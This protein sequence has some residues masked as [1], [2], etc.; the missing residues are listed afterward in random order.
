MLRN[1]Y[2]NLPT[3]Q[4]NNVKSGIWQFDMEIVKGIIDIYIL[5]SILYAIA[6]FKECNIWSKLST[7]MI[8][9]SIDRNRKV[10]FSIKTYQNSPTEVKS[11]NSIVDCQPLSE[12]LWKL[13]RKL[14]PVLLSNLCLEPMENLLQQKKINTTGQFLSNLWFVPLEYLQQK[15]KTPQVNTS[16]K[17]RFHQHMVLIKV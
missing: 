9:I 16:V 2:K 5:L 14:A 4:S 1:K 3:S 13:V 8:P 10:S 6:S 17:P 11:S 12:R 7:D 15:K